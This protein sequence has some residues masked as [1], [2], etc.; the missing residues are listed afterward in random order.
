MHIQKDEL[1]RLL[2]VLHPHWASPV[3]LL[4]VFKREFFFCILIGAML[5]TRRVQLGHCA[6]GQR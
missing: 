1:I 6:N 4:L 3:D 5:M 2:D